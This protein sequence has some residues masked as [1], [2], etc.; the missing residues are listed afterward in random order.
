MP[1]RLA[2]EVALTAIES[3]L[4]LGGSRRLDPE[5]TARFH[6]EDDVENFQPVPELSLLHVDED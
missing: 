2:Q 3:V 6:S 1:T 4:S 5:Y